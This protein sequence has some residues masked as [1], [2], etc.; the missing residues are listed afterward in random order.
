MKEGNWGGARKTRIV[1]PSFTKPFGTHTLY[2]GVGV[3]RNPPAISK[4]VAPMNAKFC[5]LLET[6]LNVLEILKFVY[7]VFTCLVTIVTPQRRCV[8]SE[9]R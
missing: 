6:S 8:S 4:T 7:V 1:N 2:Q 5:R 9:N 3:G